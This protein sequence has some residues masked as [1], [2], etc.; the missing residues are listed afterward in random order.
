G[1]FMALLKV[2]QRT[3]APLFRAAARKSYPAPK[4][5]PTCTAGWHARIPDAGRGPRASRSSSS[6]FGRGWQRGSER[7]SFAGDREV[8]RT[9]N[10]VSSQGPKTAQFLSGD[11]SPALLLPED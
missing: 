10:T 4:S 8:N 1:R 5:T 9:R 2:A 3:T 11:S 7:I 6:G